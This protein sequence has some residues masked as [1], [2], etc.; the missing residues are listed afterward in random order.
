MYPIFLWF[1]LLISSALLLSLPAAFGNVSEKQAGAIFENVEE[2]QQNMLFWTFSGVKPFSEVYF[3]YEDSIKSLVDYLDRARSG[4]KLLNE[5]I[6]WWRYRDGYVFYNR[7]AIARMMQN[8]E[9][10]RLIEPYDFL[11]TDSVDVIIRKLKHHRNLPWARITE[12]PPAIAFRDTVIAGITF[13]YHPQ[14]VFEFSL[15]W[16]SSAEEKRLK[17]KLGSLRSL[18]MLSQVEKNHEANKNLVS[19]HVVYGQFFSS[20]DE[21]PDAFELDAFSRARWGL[22]LYRRFKSRKISFLELLNSWNSQRYPRSRCQA[23]LTPKTQVR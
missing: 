6:G 11:R 5:N 4:G 21:R 3:G 19:K 12:R 18:L 9:S 20:P 15:Q 1:F 8:P 14:R 22:R 2:N 7:E 13:G 10:L 17:K 16:V 23:L